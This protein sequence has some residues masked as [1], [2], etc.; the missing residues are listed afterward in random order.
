MKMENPMKKLDG[1]VQKFING[2]VFK[3][4]NS[5]IKD[6]TNWSS[7][8]IGVNVAVPYEAYEYENQFFVRLTEILT[9]LGYSVEKS[10]D[11]GGMYTTAYISW[12]NVK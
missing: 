10:H 4:I 6:T 12:K 1:I 5:K 2:P 7:N 8:K 3:D 11:G 9:P